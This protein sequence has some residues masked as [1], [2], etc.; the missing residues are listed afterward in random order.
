MPPKRK[1]PSGRSND[2]AKG[3]DSKNMKGVDQKTTQIKSI[4]KMF[5]AM[6]VKAEEVEAF[7]RKLHDG[8]PYNL[9]VATVCSGTEAPLIALSLIRD[10]CR[11]RF[12]TDF[13]SWR[14]LFSCEIEPFKQAFIRRNHNPP[15]IFRDVVELGATGATTA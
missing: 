13:V 7:A 3:S 12:G 9:T 11:K 1:A 8:E 15:I 10:E 4:P 6:L 14:H 2:T 5:E